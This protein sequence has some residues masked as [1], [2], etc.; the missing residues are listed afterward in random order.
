MKLL[1]TVETSQVTGAIGKSDAL[2]IAQ[3]LTKVYFDHTEEADTSVNGILEVFSNFYDQ[4]RDK[5]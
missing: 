4:V 3:E 2:A 5:F 1:S